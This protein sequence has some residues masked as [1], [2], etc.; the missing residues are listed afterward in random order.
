MED[1]EGR[2]TS[3][4]RPVAESRAR[5]GGISRSLRAARDATQMSIRQDGS[6]R[7]VTSPWDDPPA[8]AVR[9]TRKA[10]IASLSENSFICG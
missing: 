4:G 1:E 2:R 3:W 10:L 8:G 6:G 9:A 7:E 5:D